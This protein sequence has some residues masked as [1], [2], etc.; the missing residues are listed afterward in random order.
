MLPSSIKTLSLSEL[1]KRSKFQHSKQVL[2][3]RDAL[4]EVLLQKSSKRLILSLDSLLKV[5]E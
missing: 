5:V 2:T 1:N 3:G 4:D